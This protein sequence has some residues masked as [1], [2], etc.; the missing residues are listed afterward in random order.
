MAKV[1][2]KNLIRKAK[3]KVLVPMLLIVS[4][5]LA[6]FQ[7]GAGQYQP[8]KV[9]PPSP[10]ASSVF[11]FTEVPVT[12][13]SGLANTSVP[14][15][16]IKAGSVNIPVNLSYHARGVRVEEIAPRVGIGWSLNYGGM[17][18]RQAR[19]LSDDISPGYLTRNFYNNVFTDV[20]VNASVNNSYSMNAIDLEP[21]MFFF[22]AA[23]LSGKFMFDQSDG[24][25][26]L[27]SYSDTRIVPIKTNSEITGWIVTDKEGNKYYFGVSKDQLRTAVDYDIVQNYSFSTAMA[28]LGSSE[29][30]PINTWHL[31][32]IETATND[33]IQFTY[34]IEQSVYYKRNYDQN[35]S[36]APGAICYFSQI[37]GRQN[38]IKDISF[39]NGKI[40]FT[41]S[42]TE[43]E[44][45]QNAYAL[46]KVELFDKNDALVKGYSFQYQYP[47][48]VQDNNQL[49]YL[50]STLPS[51]K[52]L[53]LQSIQETGRSGATIPPY[54][55]T[56][57]N[58]QLPNR[59]SNSQDAWGFYNGAANGRFLTFMQY[60]GPVDRTV[61]TVKSEAGLLKKITYPTGGSVSFTYEQNKAV[62]PAYM[63]SL[64][65]PAVNPTETVPVLAGFLRHPDYYDAATNTYSNEFTIGPN[66]IGPVTFNFEL[67]WCGTQNDE[68]SVCNYRVRLEGDG[69]NYFL[70]PPGG[71][72]TLNINPGTYKLIVKAPAGHDPSDYRNAFFA[73]IRWNEERNVVNEPNLLLAAGKR[74]KRIEYRN[75]DGTAKVK[76]FEY[77]N[78]ATGKPSGILF[79]LPNFYFILRTVIINGAPAPIVDKYGSLPG[80]PLCNL[81]GNSVGYSHV[82]EYDGDGI[83]NTGKIEYKFTTTEDG[84]KFYKFPYCTPIDN[85][86]LRGKI[87]S[88][89]VFEKTST[90]YTLK[91]ETVNKYAYAGEPQVEAIFFT[92]FLPQ[93][94]NHVYSKDRKKFYL[95]L[96]TFTKDTLFPYNF[97]VYYQTG[98]VMDLYQST[99]TEYIQGGSTLTKQTDYT[100]D[101]NKHYQSIGNETTDSRGNKLVTKL[102][103]PPD[104]TSRTAAEQKLVDLNRIST[105]VKTESIV[106]QLETDTELSKV[107]TYNSFKDWGSNIITPELVQSAT[108]ANPLENDA[109]FFSFDNY[110]NPT[111]VAERDGVHVVYLWG[112]S[113]QYPVAK[114]VAGDYNSVTSFVNLAMLANAHQYTD[115]QI[116]NE[117][118]KI[119]TGLA[120]TNALVTSY[121]YKPL[122]GMTSETDPKGR[123]IYYE[124]DALNRL[125][126]IR[127]HDNNILK[128]FDYSYQSPLEN[129]PQWTV[130]GNTRCKPCS[131]NGSY[132]SNIGQ[133]EERDTNPLSATYNQTRW[134]DAGVSSNCTVQADWQFTSTPIRCR[135]V[136]GDNTGE[137]ER[138]Q[139]D[140][141]PCSDSYGQTR[142]IV[143]GTNTNVCPLP[144][145]ATTCSGE[146]YKCVNNVCQFGIKICTRSTSLGNGTYRLYYHYE[147]SDGSLS[148]EYSEIGPFP[149]GS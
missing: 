87:D 98:G 18:S 124:Y 93:G 3:D 108:N 47:S 11:K 73:D 129:A 119:R 8:T 50:K 136:N 53:F 66:K 65:F 13:F 58:I 100:F 62:P 148:Q 130:T 51:D 14:L 89:R 22:E 68:P 84:G 131:S 78:P 92:P 90:G 12:Y 125:Q 25:V 75:Q 76:E 91:K 126:H 99:E 86:W 81:Q 112:Y 9:I 6:D 134:T 63:N 37:H 80:S 2:N 20:N 30:R 115:Q 114:V 127:D 10:E 118:N 121:T 19:G 132:T 82:T 143:T 128:K 38:Q 17:I 67:P 79:G 41:R 46:D 104:L 116:R 101:Y 135:L 142:W 113:S 72:Q 88:M 64:L 49:D 71:I 141:R 123:T 39:R 111:E 54:V 48:A 94:Q 34:E 31:M 21:D 74:I 56:Y 24:S 61:D 146:G 60:S 95:P 139:I 110:G 23:G 85:E 102:Y 29:T 109:Q 16:D 147:F 26:L 144:C 32:D 45:I 42:A 105:P 120:G 69:L 122:I 83:S 107:T 103:Y 117:L 5:L 96:I 149:C 70:Y 138:E 15:F 133:N 35:I 36:D 33:L 137:Q 145:N 52:R 106:R 28:S 7:I 77:A 43:R 40:V 27:Q 140:M 55:F 4:I 59:F 57:S 44:D 1:I 97:E